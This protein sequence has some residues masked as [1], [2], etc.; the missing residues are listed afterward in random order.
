MITPYSKILVN[1]P[2]AG[3]FLH[4]QFSCDVLALQ[5]G[6]T[7]FGAYCNIKGKV[8]CFFRLAR[9]EADYTMLM[10]TELIE[11]TLRELSKYAAFS[12][13]QLSIVEQNLEIDNEQEISDKIPEVYS[14][15]AGMFFAHDLNL[16]SIGAVSFTKG[17]YRGQEIVA[18]MQHRG[19]LKRSL[20]L[21]ECSATNIQPGEILTTTANDAAGTVVRTTDNT[22]GVSIGLAVITDSY[23]S[24]EIFVTGS[25]VSIL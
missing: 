10:P 13:V 5:D 8:E 15:T 11:Q 20:Y 24:Q 6:H 18:R 9:K 17:C 25:Q 1:G 4:G 2:D 12:K 3:K 23:A 14:A 22:A 19:N 16:P 7:T 21:F